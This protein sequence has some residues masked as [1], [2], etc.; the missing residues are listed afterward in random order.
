MY[1]KDQRMEAGRT[2]TPLVSGTV[3]K[4]EVSVTLHPLNARSKRYATLLKPPVR[5]LL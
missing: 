4:S 1:G 2:S 3:N 5:L